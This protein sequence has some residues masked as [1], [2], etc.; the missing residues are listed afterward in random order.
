MCR[1]LSRSGWE[2]VSLLKKLEQ[3]VSDGVKAMGGDVACRELKVLFSISIDDALPTLET[4]N[5][6]E[7]D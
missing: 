4:K 7:S 3:A 6:N 2:H 5:R 1:D